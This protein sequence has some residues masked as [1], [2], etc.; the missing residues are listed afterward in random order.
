MADMRVYLGIDIGGTKTAL[1]LASEESGI[2]A[3]EQFTSNPSP[4]HDMKEI[5]RLGK[6]LCRGVP[7]VAG[8]GISVGSMFDPATGC[9]GVAT[10]KPAWTGF[11]LVNHISDAFSL[12]VTAD[13][14][15]NACALAEWKYGAGQGCQ[16]LAF[17]TF[18]TGLG[19]GLILNNQVYRGASSLAGELG[20]VRIADS[21]PPLRDK[22]GCLEGYAS[23][24]G[25]AALAAL[26]CLT[27]QG[28]TSLPQHATA[29]NVANAAK[30]GDALAKA[31]LAESGDALGRGLAILI[32]LLNLEMV[33]IGSIFVRC[34]NLL[35]PSMEA[36]LKRDAIP[37]T[38]RDCRI[39]PAALGEQIGDYATLALAVEGN[40]HDPK[41]GD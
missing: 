13:N 1:S 31:I 7:D 9:F 41:A 32:D 28:E 2:L 18:G 38:L 27:W 4:E 10:H 35:R 30:H 29:E 15:A 5:I 26:R 33:V 21:G 8:I 24:A 39:V 3:R 11:P 25:I 16:H 20:S 37:D 34:D 36:A 14:D 23:G 17:L 40:C 12:P 6:G 19:A 22:P